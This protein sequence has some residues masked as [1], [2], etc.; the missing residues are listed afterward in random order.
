MPTRGTPGCGKL[1]KKPAGQYRNAFPKK[2]ILRC[3]DPR[4]VFVLRVRSSCT[5]MANP[6]PSS[7]AERETP[8]L[9]CDGLPIIRCRL[10]RP[11]LWSSTHELDTHLSYPAIRRAETSDSTFHFILRPRI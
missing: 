6:G 10:H 3:P 11:E 1:S 2:P 5:S 9:P 8:I 4:V 7:I